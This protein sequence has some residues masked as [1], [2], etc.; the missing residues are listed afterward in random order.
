M[1]ADV[2]GDVAGARQ[3]AGV[4]LASRLDPWGDV[5]GVAQEPDLVARAQGQPARV[6]GEAHGSL[7]GAYQ[8]GEP[9]PDRPDDQQL[10]GL[11]GAHQE[12]GGQFV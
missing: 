6:H 9:T 1:H 2:A 8:R 3:V 5:G 7:E 4:V 12:L 11:V 10:V